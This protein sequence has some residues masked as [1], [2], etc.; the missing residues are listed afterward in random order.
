MPEWFL[1][2]GPVMYPLLLCS[3]ISVVIIVERFLFWLLNYF[4]SND[5]RIE[6]VL[7]LVKENKKPEAL[8]AAGRSK[9]PALRVLLSGLNAPLHAAS[10]DM[11]LAAVKQ[12]FHMERFLPAMSTLITLTPLLGILG[13]VI[14]IIHSFDA[15]G[16]AAIVD[17]RGVTLGVGEAL[18]TTAFG[19]TIAIC[20]LIPYNHFSHKTVQ[21]QSRLEQTATRLETVLAGSAP[22]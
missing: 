18:I 19:L 1:K 4:R 9:D 14:G 13:T 8:K 10:Q 11:E 3:V 7:V 16:A 20:T 12:I 22:K 17:P 2:G 5:R 21:A 6:Q 15:L